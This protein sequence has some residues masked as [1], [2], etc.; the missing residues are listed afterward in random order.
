MIDPATSSLIDLRRA[1]DS[2]DQLPTGEAMRALARRASAAATQSPADAM[3]LARSLLARCPGVTIERV[4]VLEALSHV[5]CYAG[6]APQ[7]LPL[8]DEAEQIVEALADDRERATIDL[9]RVQPLARLA[10]LPE[11]ALAALRAAEALGRLGDAPA[12]ARALLNLGAVERMTG[13]HQ[14]A[15]DALDASLAAC[16]HDQVLRGAVQSNRAEVLLD[17]DRFTEAELAFESARLGPGVDEETFADLLENDSDIELVDLNYL[18]EDVNPDPGTQSIFL[19]S[20]ER[21]YRDQPSMDVIG[22]D[23]ASGLA[24]GLGVVVALID[25]GLDPTH[26]LLAPTLAPGAWNFVDG[27]ADIRDIGDG[28]DNNTNSQVDEM[29]GHGTLAAGLVVRLAPEARLMPL[30]VLDSDGGTTAF[31]VINAIYH[32][33][34]HGADI[35]NISLGSLTD[36]EF[37]SEAVAAAD[38]AGI[39]VVASAG[40]EGSSTV[41]FPAA[42]APQGAMGISATDTTDLVAPFSN[43]GDSISL[44][45]PGVSIVSLIPV[46]MGSYGEASGTSFAAP[47]V[48]GALAQLKSIAPI[49]PAAHLRAR[50]LSAAEPIDA[51]NPGF[52]GKLGAGRL[53]CFG[54]VSGVLPGRA[55]LNADG[56][57]DIDDLYLIHQSPRDLN[58]N[59]VANAQDRAL[60]EAWLRRSERDESLRR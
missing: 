19:V 52:E 30:R 36:T 27:N 28:L 14:K 32:A 20:I 16:P 39:F 59:G 38:L 25:S 34:D 31:R 56:R 55:D 57:V 15:I 53:D 3:A 51:L 37:M 54:A 9:H 41:R 17:L 6:E 11:A 42:Y 43:F 24:R 46:A 44:S 29:V 33:L 13:R 21:R 49:A 48:A 23:P 35:I 40:N 45:A 5:C 1:V 26:P 58:L 8:L 60:L 4:F 18:G 10:R 22:A 7:A 2:G 50:L 47:L 12:R